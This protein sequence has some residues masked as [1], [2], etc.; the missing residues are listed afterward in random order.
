MPSINAWLRI[1]EDRC[2]ETIPRE[3]GTSY[4]SRLSLTV[5]GHFPAS[6]QQAL[7]FGHAN[8]IGHGTRL[9][10]DPDLLQLVREQLIPLEVCLTSN[11]QTGVVRNLA[12]HPAQY[13]LSTGVPISLSTDNRLM[14]AVTLTEEYTRAKHAFG[15]TDTELAT[16]ARTGFEHAFTDPIT[17][18]NLLHQFDKHVQDAGNHE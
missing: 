17:R 1:I 13:Y 11:V 5:F 6:I 15:I 3:A 18:S 2:L 9:F 8:R 10:E 12:E 16:I 14:S 4:L 7:E